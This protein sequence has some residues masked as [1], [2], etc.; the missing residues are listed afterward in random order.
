MK[1]FWMRLA[2]YLA[3]MVGIAWMNNAVL[4]HFNPLEFYYTPTGML[5]TAVVGCVETLIIWP[6]S[7]QTI[8][9]WLLP[10]LKDGFAEEAK[11]IIVE[12]LRTDPIVT[13]F[14]DD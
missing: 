9:H 3:S 14:T 11:E 10:A 8:Q 1:K 13:E 6:A 4:L 7:K 2:I 12:E 5:L